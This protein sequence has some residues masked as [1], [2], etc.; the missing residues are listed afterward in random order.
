MKSKQHKDP[1]NGKMLNVRSV[2]YPM[3]TLLQGG[4]FSIAPMILKPQPRYYVALERNDGR[5]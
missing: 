2:T 5:K 1:I 3:R 4:T